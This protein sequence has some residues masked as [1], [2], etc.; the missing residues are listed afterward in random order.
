MSWLFSSETTRAVHQ[1]QGRIWDPTRGVVFGNVPYPAEP[2]PSRALSTISASDSEH[3]L[4]LKP[5]A[6]DSCLLKTSP[7]FSSSNPRYARSPSQSSTD[8]DGSGWVPSSTSQDSKV[9]NLDSHDAV[10]SE[11]DQEAQQEDCYEL[12]TPL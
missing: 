8:I 4:S 11:V 2:S 7:D 10:R 12:H 6:A 5:N 9:E 1:G 3:G